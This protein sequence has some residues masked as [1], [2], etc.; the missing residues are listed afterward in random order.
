MAD[1]DKV[2]I[3]LA[4][5][6]E[7]DIT[8]GVLTVVTADE[9]KGIYMGDGMNA[10]LVANVGGPG[11]SSIPVQAM[12]DTT[13]EISPNVFYIWGEMA[14]LDITLESPTDS[15]IY[16]EYMFQFTS[17][18]TA[19]VLELPETITWVSS[20]TIAANKKYQVSIVNNLGIITAF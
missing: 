7:A 15:T 1:T 16:N 19:T 14:T 3:H 6:S 9:D 11:S 10:N 4:R 20:Y 13:A 18:D 8:D 12:T 5:G 17:G 2:K